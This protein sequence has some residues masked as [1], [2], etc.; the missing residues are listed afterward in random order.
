GNGCRLLYFISF[1]GW[2]VVRELAT[3][4]RGCSPQIR[5]RVSNHYRHHPLLSC[6]RG[7]LSPKYHARKD[8]QPEDSASILVQ[9]PEYLPRPDVPTYELTT[10]K[11]YRYKHNLPS[12]TG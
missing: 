9:G 5:G 12:S 6:D 1:L 7:A 8:S 4:C 3:L 10:P 2:S 11:S